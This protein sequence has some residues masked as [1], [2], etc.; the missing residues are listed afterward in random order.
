MTE[1]CKGS[2]A[3]ETACGTC[4]RCAAEAPGYIRT[5]GADLKMVE[6]AWK[7]EL[8]TFIAPKTHLIDA[9]VIGTRNVV[10]AVR[11]ANTYTAC[12]ER[13]RHDALAA[14]TL[15]VAEPSLLDYLPK[16]E[17]ARG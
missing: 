8:G 2:W 3:L 16:E 14:K 4:A 5:L 1:N 11:R 6:N 15:G 17:A 9:L 12:V 13:W 7:R 10:A